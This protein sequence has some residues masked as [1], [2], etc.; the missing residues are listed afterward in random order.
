MVVSPQVVV[1]DLTVATEATALEVDVTTSS[2]QVIRD[3]VLDQLVE[4]MVSDILS[5]DVR[6]T[7]S[8]ASSE[9][10]KLVEKKK[11]KASAVDFVPVRYKVKTKKS[12]RYVQTKTSYEY[13]P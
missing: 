11:R 1:H 12:T 9:P 13:V 8:P 5:E 2:D 4:N 7:T 10:A 3:P 6:G